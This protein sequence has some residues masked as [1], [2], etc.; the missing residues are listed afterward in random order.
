[1]TAEPV[2]T[3]ITT[4]QQVVNA[5]FGFGP[6]D[7]A[8]RAAVLRG[9]HD[10]ELLLEQAATALHRPPAGSMP[11][12]HEAAGWYAAHGLRVFPLQPGAKR[13]YPGSHGVTDATTDL[14]QLVAWLAAAP[15]SNLGIATG[16]PYDVIDIDGPEGER[17]FVEMIGDGGAEWLTVRAVCQTPRG[18]HLWVPAVPGARNGGAEYKISV[19]YRAKGGYVVVPPSHVGGTMYRWLLPPLL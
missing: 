8:L 16:D 6:L 5:E 14:D 9:D 1:M 19:D 12:P 17:A 7:A 4:V 18:L 13:P 3:T 15:E 2:K 10:Q 11:R